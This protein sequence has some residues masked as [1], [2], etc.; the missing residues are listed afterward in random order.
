LPKLELSCSKILTYPNEALTR[1]CAS[2]TSDADF[3]LA[4]L[5]EALNG[6]NG[7]YIGVGL[8]ANQIGIDAR[9][10]I[11]RHAGYKMDLVNP[12]IIHKT[13]ETT[14]EEEGCLSL[15]NLYYRIRRPKFVTI[16]ADNFEGSIRVYNETIS[17][18]VQHE[19]EHT[20][21]RGIWCYYKTGRNEPC[22]CGSGKKFKKCCGK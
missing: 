5:E 18:I 19:I 14:F 8:S 17:R 15:P 22:F 2:V 3:I 11:I 21:G 20:M 10:C 6:G 9:V 7:Q 1:P 13:K 16:E 12:R 4:A